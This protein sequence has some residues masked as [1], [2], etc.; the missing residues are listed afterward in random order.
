MLANGS[1]GYKGF[2]P[3]Y[4]NKKIEELAGMNYARFGNNLFLFGFPPLIVHLE[5]SPIADRQQQDFC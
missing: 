4:G 2:E 5:P 3:R 1:L